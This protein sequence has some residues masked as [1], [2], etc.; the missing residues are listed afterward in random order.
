MNDLP[1]FTLTRSYFSIRILFIPLFFLGGNK[2]V[3]E[4]VNRRNNV[5][6]EEGDSGIDANSL[7]SCSS[8]EVKVSSTERQKDKKSKKTQQTEA[9]I[10]DILTTTNTKR[11]SRSVEKFSEINSSKKKKKKEKEKEVVKV[12]IFVNLLEKGRLLL[13]RKGKITK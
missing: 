6:I 7:G 9:P 1:V 2:R 5:D 11:E 10:E 4:N 3:A 13:S 8:N 12:S